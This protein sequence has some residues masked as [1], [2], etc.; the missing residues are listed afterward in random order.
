MRQFCFVK[1]LG[2]PQFEAPPELLVIT[3]FSPSL[4]LEARALIV[5]TNSTSPRPQSVPTIYP[6]VQPH[7]MTQGV[8]PFYGG[9]DRCT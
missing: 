9:F 6:F 8:E 7:M 4:T 2:C 5:G 1:K 3:V